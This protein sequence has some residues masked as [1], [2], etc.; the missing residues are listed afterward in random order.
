MMNHPRFGPSGNDERFYAEGFKAT[1]QAPQWVSGLGLELFEYSFGNGIIISDKTTTEIGLEAKKNNIEISVHAP[2]FISLASE[3][4]N[5][6]ENSYGYVIKSLQKLDLF[7]GKNCVVHLASVGKQSREEA[8][9]KVKQNLDILLQKVEEA[10]LSHL[11]ICPETMGK[12]LQIGTVDEIID[13]CT[14]GKNLRPTFDFGHINSLEQGSMKTKFDYLNVF[15]RAL[16]KLDEEKV[17]N[18]HIHFSKIMY[19]PKGEIKHLTLEDNIYG[20]EFEPL[21]EAIHELKLTP[22]IISES[23]NVMADDAAKL[24]QMYYNFLQR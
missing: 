11:N 23:K 15:E 6:V 12:S 20:P 21:A 14:Q 3:N 16:K 18:C 24:R 1:L 19:G 7:G 5:T 2:Y 10:G 4:P 13:F 8:V 17:K 22:T 9:L